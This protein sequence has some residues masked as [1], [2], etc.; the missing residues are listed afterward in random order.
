MDRRTQYSRLREL[1]DKLN[2][3]ELTLDELKLKIAQEIAGTAS[4]IQNAGKLM[5]MSGM[6]E[7]LG[8]SRFKVVKNAMS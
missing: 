3:K 2:G 8:N 1:A 6:L 4:I 5:V 7:D